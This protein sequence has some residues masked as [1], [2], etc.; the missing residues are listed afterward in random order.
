MGCDTLAL[1]ED[2]DRSRRQPR[3]DFLAQ[4]LVRHRVVMLLD[5]DV[6]IEADAAL[7]PFGGCERNSGNVL[8]V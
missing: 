1:V 5:L 3:P 7:L 2:F 6:V 8:N 4:Q